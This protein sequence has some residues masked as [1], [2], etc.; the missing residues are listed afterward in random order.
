MAVAP[1]YEIGQKVVVTPVK[2]PQL[3][4]RDSDL[5]S[6]TGRRGEITDYHWITLDRGTKIFYI[7]TVKINE[8]D[9]KL[10]LHEDELEAAIV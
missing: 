1:Q 3:S 9:K 8:D 7:Y 10:I 5:E 4:P 6:Y 2:N